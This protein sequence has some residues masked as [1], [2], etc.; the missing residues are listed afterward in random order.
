MINLEN[1]FSQYFK[2]VNSAL[3]DFELY[4][5]IL[6]NVKENETKI[7]K[8]NSF[9]YTILNALKYSFVM[10]TAK[11]IDVREDKNI[12]RFINFCKVNKNM[13]LKEIVNDYYNVETKEREYEFIR[14][15]DV[16]EDIKKF[17]IE[18]DKYSSQIENIKAQRDKI[19]AHNDKKYFY[20]KGNINQEF[21]VTY[22]DIDNILHI[23][24]HNLNILSIDYNRRA[25]SNYASTLDEY[26]YILNNL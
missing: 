2:V 10:Q 14:K 17:E 24:Y 3:D 19:Y 15:V 13:F 20:D 11:L 8:I 16:L 9:L 12:F 22:E 6:K 5:G 26:L 7:N 1:E 23:I 4:K 21:K 25:Y 18:L